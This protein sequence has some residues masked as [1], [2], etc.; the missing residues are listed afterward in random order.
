MLIKKT[1]SLCPTC[2]SVIDAEI[3]EEEG[4]IWLKQT[5]QEHGVFRNLYWSDADMYRRFDR[6]D[7]VGRGI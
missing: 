4:K 3:A 6:F 2:Y 1:R 5:C 7:A